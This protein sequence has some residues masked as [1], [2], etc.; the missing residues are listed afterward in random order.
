MP[1]SRRRSSRRPAGPRRTF[2]W[3]S[4]IALPLTIGAGATVVADLLLGVGLD[5]LVG[6]RLERFIVELKFRSVI[7]GDNIQGGFY[8]SLQDRE[9]LGTLPDP[10]LEDGRS[11]YTRQFHTQQFTTAGEPWTIYHIDQTPKRKLRGSEETLV[12]VVKNSLTSSGSVNET[13]GV[14]ILLS[15]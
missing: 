7:S 5:W 3:F 9:S 6:V 13:A 11:L 2:R 8:F 4:N 12:Q 15:K 14:R 10:E 1:S